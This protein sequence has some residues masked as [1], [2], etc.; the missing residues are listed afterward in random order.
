MSDRSYTRRR[1]LQL[2]SAGLLAGLAGCSGGGNGGNGDSGNGGNGDSGN[3]GNGGNGG[4][5]SGGSNPLESVPAGS[6]VVAH[7]DAG[8][9]LDGPVLRQGV[10]ETIA[11]LSEQQPAYSGPESYQD[12]LSMIESETGLSPDALESMTMF[13]RVTNTQSQ[14]PGVIVDADWEESAVLEALESQGEASLSE[15]TYGSAT[16]YTSEMGTGALGVLADGRYV[17]GEAATIESV[18][19]VVSG[20]ADPVGGTV[21]TAFGNAPSGPLRFGVDLTQATAE[22]ATGPMA[23][24]EQI[25][26]GM[27]VEGDQRRMVVEMQAND[28]NSANGLQTLLRRGLDQVQSQGQ[29]SPDMP[30]QFGEAIQALDEVQIAQEGRTVSAVYSASA[31]EAGVLGTM[32]AA[33]VASFVLGFGGQEEVRAPQVSFGFDFDMDAETVTITHEAGDTV[34]AGNLFVVTEEGSQN[35]A[36]LSENLSPTEDVAAGSRVTT[37]VDAG[38]TTRVVW[39]SE[40]RSAVLAEE[41][42]PQ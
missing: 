39:E 41:R 34:Q 33:V 9:L 20:D 2:G 24:I 16:V 14:A 22:G 28:E 4:D 35:W 15:G 1:A 27:G 42:A 6:T 23:S 37:T 31:E 19:D 10:E 30:S 29:A 12:V 3:G 32:F 18:V 5:G 38:E 25:W 21:V 17:V 26:G 13:G 36:S 8:T 40:N 7:V 11:L